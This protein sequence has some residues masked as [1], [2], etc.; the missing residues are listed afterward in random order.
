MLKVSFSFFLILLFS[1]HAHSQQI[2]LN[3]DGD[4]I[5]QFDDGSWR[6][7]QL[8][9]SIFE[10]GE[11]AEDGT[12]D[13][14]K[15]TNDYRMFQRYVVAAV[16]YEAEHVKKL[17]VSKTAFH[18]LEDKLQSAQKNGESTEELELSLEEMKTQVQNDQRLVA[19]SRSLIKKILKIGAKEQYAK[20]QKIYV[21]GLS[22]IKLTDEQL[23]ETEEIIASRQSNKTPT[24]L[25]A[26]LRERTSKKEK[27]P[28]Q[29]TEK[30]VESVFME[31][32]EPTPNDVDEDKIT[33]EESTEP[34][35]VDTISSVTEPAKETAS[36]IRP[37]E[38]PTTIED[39]RGEIAQEQIQ[40]QEV[41]PKYQAVQDLEVPPSVVVEE[42]LDGRKKAKLVYEPVANL[43]W[44]SGVMSAPPSYVCQFVHDGIDEFTQQQK[45]E[46]AD[47]VFFYHTDD[48][49]KTHMKGRDYVHCRGFLTSISGG[50]RHLTLAITIA[51]RNAR[52]EYGYIKSGSLL[53]IK[54]L[55][56]STVSL[57]SQGDQLGTINSS[58]GSTT[59]TIKYPI[60]F[61][62]EKLLSREEVDRV[63]IVWSTGYEDYEV[64]NVD[65]FQNQLSCLNQK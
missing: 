36:E 25:L 6:Y 21:P 33:L 59:Y 51:S 56:G 50:F 2:K 53:N 15:V 49:L 24:P 55:D 61:Q 7:Y 1:F 23:N 3:K 28:K 52:R 30:Q 42:T 12:L 41:K 5:V 38:G 58:D 19:Y 35:L 11:N 13:G 14:S 8:K 29:K 45:R 57:F 17:D 26:K 62:K 39:G 20:L 63:R 60:D 54:M 47:E 27:K 9:D 18:S 22:T 64:Y 34:D 4:K 16:S 32:P 44:E 48:R 10:V 40:M 65:F 31:V 43:N 46:L 37:V